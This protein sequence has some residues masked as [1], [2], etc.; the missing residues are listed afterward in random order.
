MFD[1][2]DADFSSIKINN[3]IINSKNDCLDFFWNH[4]I[5]LAYL[6]KC[7]DNVSWRTFF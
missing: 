1:P 3:I 4:K 7:G 6:N 2:V 5:D